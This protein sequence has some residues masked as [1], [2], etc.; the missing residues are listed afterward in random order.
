M[1][2]S[3]LFTQMIY[4]AVFLVFSAAAVAMTF[5]NDDG[6]NAG[7]FLY[8]TSWSNWMIFA[9]MAAVFV[10]TARRYARG[11]RQGYN[12]TLRFF[13]FNATVIIFVTFAV[14]AFVLP[15]APLIFK[16][17]Y[18]TSASNLL[19]HFLCPLL[20]VFDWILFDAHHIVKPHWPFVGLLLPLSYCIVVE[21]RAGIYAGMCGG[22]IPEAELGDYFP[23][24]FLNFQTLGIGGLL[25]WVGILI[26][27]FLALGFVVYGVDKAGKNRI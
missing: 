14:Y 13:K 16:P 25:M 7:T 19:K 24:F 12:K 6:F 23:Y 18:W 5:V 22:T 3:S 10:G 21:A 17:E 2:I 11:E 27:V 15:E 26:C 8:Y 4:R 20:F 9:V 1:R